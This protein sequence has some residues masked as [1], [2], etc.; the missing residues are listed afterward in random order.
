MS[1]L[2]MSQ[3]KP[4]AAL[5]APLC[6]ICYKDVGKTVDGEPFIAC[7]VC[8]FPVCRLCYEDEREDGKQSCPQCNTRYKRHKGKQNL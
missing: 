6:Q 3:G 4:M 5:S 7:N 2:I 1:F 8:V